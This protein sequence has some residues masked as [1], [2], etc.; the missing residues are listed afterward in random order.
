MMRVTCG[1][2]ISLYFIDRLGS[3]SYPKNTGRICR[4]A[5]EAQTPNRIWR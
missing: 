1:L 2:L 4:L 5:V 3:D